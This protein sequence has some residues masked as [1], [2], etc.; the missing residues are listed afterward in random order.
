MGIGRAV[1]EMTK[2]TRLFRSGPL[3]RSPVVYALSS[4][5]PASHGILAESVCSAYMPEVEVL[6]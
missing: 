3:L 6:Q 4:H 1:L 2:L 5:T